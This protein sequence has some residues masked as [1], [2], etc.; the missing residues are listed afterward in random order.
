MNWNKVKLG[1]V[2]EII[3]K[4][5]TP[6]TLG[7]AFKPG[8][9]PFLRVQNI[10]NGQV[11]LNG[12]LF[13]NEETDQVLKRSRI[14]PNDLLIS[15]AGT[16]GRCALVSS[17]AKPMNCNQA[18]AIV[19]IENQAVNRR[20]LLRWLETDS[21]KRKMAGAQVTGTISNLSLTQVSN[22]EIPLPP[23][24]EQQRLAAI[25]DGADALRALRR[26]AVAALDELAQSLFLE[27]FGDPALNPKNWELV[28]LGEIC[29]VKGGKRL[30]KGDD[31]SEVPTPFRYIRVSDLKQGAVRQEKLLYLK[32]E[33]QKQI[34]RYIVHTGDIIISIAGSIGLIAPVPATLDGANLTENAA[35]LKAKKDAYNSIFLSHLLQTN[36]AQSQIGSQTAQVTIGKLALFRI[37]SI[38]IPLP[39]LALQQEFA[40]QI[41][42]LETLKARARAQAVE[43]DAL[44]GALSARA[45]AGELSD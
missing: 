2:C 28:K 25:L 40:I 13:I 18:V 10:Q 34:S 44:F 41:G 23:L 7:H 21:A 45:F 27:L 9:I 11:D 32:P 3:T 20:F 15:I 12:A 5:T 19:R 24:A 42:Q 38:E 35:K 22:L 30:P 36:Y 33:T 31:Y 4:G 14:Q 17:D 43:L 29:E 26:D 8:G 37:E 1:D 16:I 39:P 6:T